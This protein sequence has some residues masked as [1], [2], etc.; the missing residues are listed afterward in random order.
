MR[1][2]PTAATAPPA[3]PE[4]KQPWYKRAWQRFTG[5]LR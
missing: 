4:P 5:W 3:T 1:G 2:A